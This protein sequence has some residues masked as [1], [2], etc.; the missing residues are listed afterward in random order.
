MAVALSVLSAG[1]I[2]RS[3]GKVAELFER[4]SGAGVTTDFAPAPKIRERILAGERVDVVIASGNALDALAKESRIVIPSRAVV[5]RTCMAVM[6][7]EGA[8]RPDLS[9]TAAFK[10]S[11][12]DADLLVYNEGS[13]GVHAA[14]VMDKLGLREQMGA[15][16]RVAPRGA[17][18]I[19]LVASQP[20]RVMGLSQLTNILDQVEKGIPVALGG[21][22][23]GEIQKVTSYEIAVSAD[24]RDPELAGAFVR[25]FA[26]AEARKLLAAAGLN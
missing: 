9:S 26:S 17:D 5:G 15:K 24:A 21:V 10:R 6:V 2:R 22:F 4:Q 13:S 18:M 14:A 19:G 8:P 25:A 11:M 23:P 3:V 20:G 12:L 16:I 7:R 1:A